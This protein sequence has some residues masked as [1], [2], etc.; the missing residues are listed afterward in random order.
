[1]TEDHHKHLDHI[2]RTFNQKCVTKYVS[3]NEEHGGFLPDKE[4][5]IDM[6][7][8]EAI[9]QV[10]YLVTLKQQ[11]EKA[12]EQKEVQHKFETAVGDEIL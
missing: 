9:D 12:E 1:M 10:I 11:L 4:G 7:I 3:G 2:L 8:E 5:I 6:A